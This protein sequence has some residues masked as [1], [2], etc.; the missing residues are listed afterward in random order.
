MKRI[1]FFLLIAILIPFTASSSEVVERF[2]IEKKLDNE[3]RS[4]IDAQLELVT[5]YIQFYI[6]KEWWSSLEDEKKVEYKKHIYNLGKEFEDNIYPNVTEFFGNMPSH[7]VVN[8]EEKITVLFHPMQANS[9]GYFNSGDQYSI[10]QHA[11][12][13]E[14]NIL[15][16]NT[17]VIDSPNLAGYLAH[18]YIHLVTFNEKNKTHG[19]MEEIWLNELRAEVIITILGYDN[20]NKSNLNNRM[21]TFLRDPDISLTEWT[22]Q[23]ADYGVVNLFGQYVLDHYG[24]EIFADSLKT[25]T[26]GIRSIND[27]LK[28]NGIDKSFADIFTEWSIAV[29]LNNCRYGDFFCYKNEKLRNISV[30]PATVFI[31]TRDSGPVKVSYQTKNWAGNWYRIIGG[32]GTLHLNFS[33]EERFV[34]PYVLCKKSGECDIFSAYINRNGEG[35]IVVENFNSIYESVTIIP[36][37][38]SKTSG[39]NGAERTFSFYWEAEIKSDEVEDFS[40]VRERLRALRRGVEYIYNLLGLEL[41]D[42]L[43]IRKIENNLYYGMSNSKEVENLQ[44]FLKYQGEEVYP[45]GYVTGNF[46]NLTKNAV[47]RFQEKYGEQILLPAGL[48]FGTGYVGQRTRDVINSLIKE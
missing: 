35:S 29:Y 41:P 10:Y 11:R 33:S 25:K 44:R 37:L 34:L 20:H 4:R 28:K 26:T 24:K 39:F 15:Y 21:D 43:R 7:D 36:S 3:E 12:S 42:L 13:N 47:I 38:Q 18:E 23:I 30:S 1:V 22:E 16:L 9:G 46:Y 31:P 2:F 14:R 17:G 6:D 32:S 48:Q 45:E 27:A 8:R 40:D 5:S 19:V